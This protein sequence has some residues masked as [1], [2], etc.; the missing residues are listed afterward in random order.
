MVDQ[1]LERLLAIEPESD[2][3]ESSELAKA[4]SQLLAVLLKGAKKYKIEMGTLQ[5]RTIEEEAIPTQYLTELFN[6]KEK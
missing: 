1:I 4:K 3:D 2:E 6:V 5:S